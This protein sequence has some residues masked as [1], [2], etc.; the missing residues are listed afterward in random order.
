MNRD[1]A[2]AF[3]RYGGKW[4]WPTTLLLRCERHRLPAGGDVILSELAD[5]FSLFT[6]QM[7]FSCRS[8]V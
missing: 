5:G 7:E 4:I 2:T 1:Y 8:A 3:P 6:I